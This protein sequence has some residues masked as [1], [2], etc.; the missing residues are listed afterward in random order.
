MTLKQQI[1]LRWLCLLIHEEKDKQTF[2]SL[3]EE[4]EGLLAIRRRGLRPTAS[5]CYTN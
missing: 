5:H 4:L 2:D 1:R 3:I